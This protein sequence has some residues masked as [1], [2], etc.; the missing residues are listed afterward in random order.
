MNYS[1][2][3]FAE[4][5]NLWNYF[6]CLHNK[7]TGRDIWNIMLL[8]EVGI[9]NSFDDFREVIKNPNNNE[10]ETIGSIGILNKS[11]IEINNL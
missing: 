8:N 2:V 1:K 11:K 10:Y 9:H 7:L 5:L 3:S 6:N 4:I